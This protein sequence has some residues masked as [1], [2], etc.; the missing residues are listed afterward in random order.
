MYE[1]PNCGS[2]LETVETCPNCKYNIA[3][4]FS[5]PFKVSGN[6]VHEHIECNIEGLDYEVCKIYLKQAGIKTKE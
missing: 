1:C 4:T 6:C 3:C 2:M 5:C